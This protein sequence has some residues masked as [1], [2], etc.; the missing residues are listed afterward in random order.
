V[1]TTTKIEID[2]DAGQIPIGVDGVAVSMST[3]VTCT[4]APSALR[5]WVPRDRRAS[6]RRSPR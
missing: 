5:I 3:P 1:L 6:P 2:A 4:I